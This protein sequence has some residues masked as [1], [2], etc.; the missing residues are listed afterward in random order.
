MKTKFFYA[1]AS[2]KHMRNFITSLQDSSGSVLFNHEQK[3]TLIWEDF[4]ERLDTSAFETMQFDL[5]DL[6]HN[7]V[8]LSPLEMSFSIPKIDNVVKNLPID[9]SP[10]LDEFNNEFIKRCW[11]IIKQD[12]YNICFAFHSGEVCLQSIN[13]SF[14]T[15]IPKVD[16]PLR[17]NDFR[18][19]SLLNCCVKFI[20]KLLANRL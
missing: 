19:I 3:A 6:L 8:D 7:E 5:D 16:D 10:G 12:F 15:L 4:R 9:K 17:I 20:T 2:I 18:P 13:G 14:I 1:N 11:S